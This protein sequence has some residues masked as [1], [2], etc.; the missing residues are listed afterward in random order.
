MKTK[1]IGRKVLFGQHAMHLPSESRFRI[2]R[3]RIEV[4]VVCG[5]AETR[6]RSMKVVECVNWVLIGDF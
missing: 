5:R 4:L 3:I 6:K 1:G 2:P